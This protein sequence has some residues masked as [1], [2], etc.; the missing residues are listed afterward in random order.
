MRTKLTF[1]ERQLPVLDTNGGFRRWHRRLDFG[2]SC[3]AEKVRNDPLTDWRM[4]CR[5][6]CATDNGRWNRQV[7]LGL[8]QLPPTGSAALTLLK[9]SVVTSI[10][11]VERWSD[12]SIDP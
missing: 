5:F 4:S 2:T 9:S 1:D 11:P 8:P 3:V 12:A 10:E 7:I 6:C